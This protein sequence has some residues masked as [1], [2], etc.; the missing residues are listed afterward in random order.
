MRGAVPTPARSIPPLFAPTC[1]TPL[2]LVLAAMNRKRRRRELVWAVMNP[3]AR[4]WHGLIMDT[5]H[6]D[7]LQEGI[8]SLEA[9]PIRVKGFDDLLA[10]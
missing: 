10:A 7:K 8:L 6:R 1:T 4:R 5:Y 9:D 2:P 3:A